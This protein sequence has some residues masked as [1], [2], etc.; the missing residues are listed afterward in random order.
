MAED[1][2]KRFQDAGNDFLETARTRAEEFLRELAK[3]TEST[4]KQ[5]QDQVDDL[6]AAGRRGKLLDVVRREV[7][8]QLSQLGVATKRDLDALERR[9]TGRAPAKKASTKK[10]STKK[11]S[12]TKKAPTKRASATKK[13]A[14]TTTKKAASK[15]TKKASDQTSPTASG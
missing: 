15:T 2:F 13:A 12:A 6:V 7:Q 11:A 9:V 8:T 5:A 10:A 3:V 14:K 4:Q 1:R